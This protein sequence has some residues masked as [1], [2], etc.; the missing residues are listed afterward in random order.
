MLRVLLPKAPGYAGFLPQYREFE[1][2]SSDISPGD[3]PILRRQEYWSLLSG[4]T[5]QFYGNRYTWQFADGWKDHINTPGSAQVRYLAQLFTGRPWFRLVP[6]QRH[7]IITEGYG[8]FASSGS[9][10]SSDYVTAAA[11]PDGRLAIAYLSSGGKITVDMS[12]LAG[13]VQAQWYD[14]T[15]GT[16]APVARSPFPNSGTVELTPPDKNADGDPDWVLVLTA[17]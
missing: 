12:R 3:P 13:T 7:Q 6:D 15:N 8:T 2:N 9:V 16:Y 4:A 11:T 17:R 1:Q 10:G 5:G 14:P